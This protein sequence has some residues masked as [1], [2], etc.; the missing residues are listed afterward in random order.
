MDEKMK[1][2]ISSRA[3]A[4]KAYTKLTTT[5]IETEMSGFILAGSIISNSQTLSP[6]QE[7]GPV[8]DLNAPG[9]IDGNTGKTFSHEW[10]AG[11]N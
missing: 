5:S 8:Y 2:A 10:E 3:A 4:R 6:G 11:T 7:F 9:G 1:K